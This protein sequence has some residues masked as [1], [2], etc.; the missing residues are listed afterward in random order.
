MADMLARRSTDRHPVFLDI[1][2]PTPAKANVQIQDI[3]WKQAVGRAIE[4]A[5][6]AW[7]KT[8]SEAAGAVGVDEAEFGKWLRGERRPHLDRLFAIDDLRPHLI[9]ALARLDESFAIEWQIRRRLA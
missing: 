3:D 8:K 1:P 6:M 5:V 2:R 9:V 4:R 7:G